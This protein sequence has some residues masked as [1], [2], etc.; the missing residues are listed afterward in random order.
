[1]NLQT[2]E[3][4]R[5][6][7]G[8][9]DSGKGEIFQQAIRHI[10]L[11]LCL[12]DPT[13]PDNPIVYA[14]DAFCTMTGYDMEEVVGRNCRFLQGPG[15]TR[16]SIDRIR[17]ILAG[18]ELA[19]VELVN[20]RKDGT[21][22]VNALQLGPIAGP[23]GRVAFYFG[24]Q[25]DVSAQRRQ[26]QEAADLRSRELLHR[27]RNIV[28]VMAVVIK[29]TSRE[30]GVSEAFRDA[31]TGRLIALSHAHFDTFGEGETQRS[32][33]LRRLADTILHAYAPLREAQVTLSGPDVVVADGQVTPIT[34]ILH[35]LSTNAIKY[36]AL[37]VAGGQ[38]DLAWTEEDGRLGIVWRE[39]GGPVVEPPS[40][41]GG[42]EIMRSLIAASGG[43]IGFDWRPEG[44][45][46]R[47]GLPTRARCV[48]DDADRRQPS[49]GCG[50]GKA[51]RQ[52]AVNRS[53]DPRTGRTPRPW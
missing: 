50:T 17:E 46:A 52:S 9:W 53:R 51:S 11:P 45:V 49:A 24:S 7:T 29:M 35:E 33:D 27:L 22:F 20:Y 14:N 26:E 40:R 3:L 2:E 8:S 30:H 1:M 43:E 4:V 19:T 6:L 41:E 25:L 38:V 36:G 23:D 37:S 12:S 28:N 34:L 32:V 10:R 48:G 21:A 15:T 44:L 39:S 13:R 5:Q 16:E 42:S 31:I 47:I 18:E